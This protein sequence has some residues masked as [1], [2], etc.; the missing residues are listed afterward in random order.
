MHTLTLII[1]TQLFDKGLDSAGIMIG[2]F[3]V[4]L[5]FF[6]VSSI[7][8]IIIIIVKVLRYGSLQSRGWNTLYIRTMR[9]PGGWWCSGWGQAFRW[10]KRYRCRH[11]VYFSLLVL[12]AFSALSSAS[13]HLCDLARRRGAFVFGMS[14]CSIITKLVPH[15]SII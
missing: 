9:C 11:S 12:A 6:V 1:F 7:T 2:W 4:I 5:F 10:N 8:I 15:V 13:K 3:T 14:S